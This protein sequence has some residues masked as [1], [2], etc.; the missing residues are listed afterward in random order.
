M[1]NCKK[2]DT[3]K[4]IVAFSLIFVLFVGVFANL[5]LVLRDNSENPAP[6]QDIESSVPEDNGVINED[7]TEMVSGQ[8]Y[9]MA[10]SMTFSSPTLLS[11]TASSGITLQCSVYPITASNKAV[12]WSVAWVNPSSSWAS[13]KTA[14]SYLSVTPSSS[15]ST[16][17]TVVCN[18]AFGEPINIIVTSRDN[19]DITATCVVDYQKRMTGYSATVF[20]KTA[21]VTAGGTTS[22]DV[23]SSSTVTLGSLPLSATY[24]TGTVAGSSA[25][26]G[27]SIMLDIA[28]L[29][30]KIE[31]YYW[32]T[33]RAQLGVAMQMTIDGN[34]E[35]VR[36]K[37]TQMVATTMVNKPSSLTFKDAIAP[38]VE[39]AVLTTCVDYFSEL[40]ASQPFALLRV[41]VDGDE[42]TYGDIEI[43]VTDGVINLALSEENLII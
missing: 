1:T 42:S 34:I 11:T 29:A 28:G 13:G 10:K 26:L 35:D 31:N 27:C 2:S 12:D 22:I 8:V 43:Y 20:G 25:T 40:L 4:W 23:S 3:V 19:P 39:L 9:A 33:K 17:A 7:G 30:E 16:T 21:N 15:G 18:A 36:G 37:C 38:F 6:E 5:F 41:G 24:G 32:N 14:S